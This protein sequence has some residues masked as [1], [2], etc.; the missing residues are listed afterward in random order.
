MG[1]FLR[2]YQIRVNRI[3]VLLQILDCLQSESGSNYTSFVCS[4]FGFGARLVVDFWVK[5]IYWDNLF[6]PLKVDC[7]IDNVIVMDP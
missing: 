2:D 3:Q 1:G 6:R 7:V 5:A 4:I